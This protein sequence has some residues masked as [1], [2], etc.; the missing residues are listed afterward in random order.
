MLKYK[1]CVC[2]SSGVINGQRQEETLHQDFFFRFIY[3]LYVYKVHCHSLQTHQKR[4]SDAI[5][6]DCEPPGGCWELNSGSLEEQ[7]MLLT[8]EPALLLSTQCNIIIY[9]NHQKGFT[10]Q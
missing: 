5:T 1:G 6:N 7:S 4:A 8:A 10:Q 9:Y 3:L 2:F